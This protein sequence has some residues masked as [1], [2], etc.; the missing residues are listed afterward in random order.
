MRFL[1]FQVIKQFRDEELEHHDTGL[2]HDAELVGLPVTGGVPGTIVKVE[3]PKVSVPRKRHLKA[4][5]RRQGNRYSA[6]S[7]QA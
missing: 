5:V 2:D 7:T 1:S 3:G 6:E 4:K